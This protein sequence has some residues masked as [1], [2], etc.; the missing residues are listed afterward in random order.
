MTGT[1][2]EDGFCARCQE[3]ADWCVCPPLPDEAAQDDTYRE[4]A[5]AATPRTTGL[6]EQPVPLGATTRLPAFPVSALPPWLADQVTQTARFTQTPPD[7][8]AAVALAV[9]SA[10]AGGRAVVEV[11]GSWREPVNLYTVTA[12]PPGAR[13]SAVFA[14][15]TR[16]LLDTEASMVEGSRGKIL[17]A[18]TL[19]KIALREADKAAARA[20][21]IEDA[22][23][24]AKA[25]TDAVAQAQLA[26]AIIVGVIPG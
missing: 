22:T 20:A 6:W 4:D 13:K 2:G 12:L 19:R 23:A 26:E 25:S 17:E 5:P 3:P 15:M 9:L 1:I 11:R 10:A 21:G 24:R 16:P 8:P 14:E 7:L 18:D